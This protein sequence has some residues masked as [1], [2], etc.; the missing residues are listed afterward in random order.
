MNLKYCKVYYV[1]FKREAFEMSTNF[2]L[3][4]LSKVKVHSKILSFLGDKKLIIQ[5]AM[6]INA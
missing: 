1:Y 2:E 4:G 3:I 6:Q 5:R